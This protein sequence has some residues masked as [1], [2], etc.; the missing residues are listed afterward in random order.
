MH[1]NEKQ[2]QLLFAYGTLQQESVQLATFGR[3]LEGKADTLVG[4]RLTF[5]RI[6]DE[7]FVATSGTARHRNLEFTGDPSDVV[8]GAAF[9]VTNAELEQAD[10]YE[11][12]G[13]TRILVQLKSGL[14]AWVYFV[15]PHPTADPS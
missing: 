12:S 1:L 4:Y 13:Y 9:T 14:N 15:H 6:D 8:E 5:V 3:T 11:P 10:A 7:D 2:F